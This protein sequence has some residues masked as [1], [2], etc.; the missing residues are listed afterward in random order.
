MK[1]AV[2]H[3]AGKP[4]AIET[5]AD[6][7]PGP[8]DVIIKVHRCGIC[9]TDLHMTSGH[10]WDFPTGS[11]IGHEYAGE[12]VALG[13]AVERL[14]VGDRVSGMAKA[15]C[16]A[17][18]ACFRGLQLLCA[19][20]QGHGMGGFGEYL[21][22]PEGA[23][24]RLPRTF[25]LADG[26]LVEPL[27]IGLHG[28]R[29]ADLPIGAKV[30]VLGAGSVGLATI[31]W[32]KRLGAARVVATSR[33]MT[34]EAMALAMG[35]DAFVQTGV[36]EVESAVEALGGQPEIVFECAGAPGL[37]GRAIN[38]VK[39]F[40]QVLSLGFCTAPDPVIP[41]IATFK[42]VRISF[43]LAYTPGEFRSVADMMLAGT[44]DPKVMIT[45]TIGL[46]DLPVKFEALRGPNDHTKVHVLLKQDSK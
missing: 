8:S 15:G 21:R 26:A 35:A 42:Q 43:P 30:L 12:V 41:A 38:H 18:E 14:R 2:F 37:L 25:S 40:G 32:A 45:S 17:C 5:V 6:P 28:V 46:N 29:M 27:A 31:F 1:A 36:D 24:A 7:E 4:L 10:G 44:V 13:N 11:I 22:L 20:A 23:A 19:K 33:S 9:G 16:G 3:G 34:R 39:Q